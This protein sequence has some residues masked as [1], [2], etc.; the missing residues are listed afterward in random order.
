MQVVGSA[1]EYKDVVLANMDVFGVWNPDIDELYIPNYDKDLYPEIYPYPDV[2]SCIH[3]TSLPP[4]TSFR[5]ISLDDYLSDQIESGVTSTTT[6]KQQREKEEKETE[7]KE[8]IEKE[9]NKETEKE[10]ERE[11][12]KRKKHKRAVSPAQL[13]VLDSSVS[14]PSF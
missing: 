4:Q 1:S 14:Q 10:K 7:G 2:P 12:T 5:K 9:N 8:V 13:A 3:F 6:T 11:D